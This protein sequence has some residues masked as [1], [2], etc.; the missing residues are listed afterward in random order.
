MFYY[1]KVIISV[2]QDKSGPHFGRLRLVT[3][4]FVMKLPL[5]TDL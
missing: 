2:T 1:V 4:P 3:G 5:K